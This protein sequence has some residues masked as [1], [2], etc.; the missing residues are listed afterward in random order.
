[1]NIQDC[2]TWIKNSEERVFE[3]RF[4]KRSNGLERVMKCKYGVKTELVSN[5]TKEGIDV[6]K[7]NVIIV[8]D[9]EKHAYRSI[10]IESIIAIK[11]Y[12]S[13]PQFRELRVEI[14]PKDNLHISTILTDDELWEE[15]TH[16]IRSWI[17][18]I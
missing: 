16:D 5:P 6:E 8:W 3:I 9:T 11:R 14:N 17:Y 18:A 10:G 4:R 12:F 1:M 7:S 2:V 15:V 13:Y